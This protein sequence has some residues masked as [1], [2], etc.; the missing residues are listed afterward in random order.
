MIK[1]FS[2]LHNRMGLPKTRIQYVERICIND[3]FN[4]ILFIQRWMTHKSRK[5]F[6]CP[7]ENTNTEM[8]RFK[9]LQKE[10]S[11][12]DYKESFTEMV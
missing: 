5:L 3:C 9:F 8:G 6:N 10:T 11:P 2:G 12:E 1:L 4:R 7:S